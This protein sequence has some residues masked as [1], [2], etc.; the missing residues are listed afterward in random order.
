MALAKL[1]ELH[2]K[3]VPEFVFAH[4]FADEEV[5]AS[6]QSEQTTQRLSWVFAFLA[7]FISS[8]GLLGLVMFT[9]E[10][11]TKEVSIRKVLGASGSQVAALLS[12]D[13]FGLIL[14]A[15]VLSVPVSNFLLTNW[16]EGYQYRITIE[17]WT[18]A[19]AAGGAIITAL[20]TISFQTI[21]AART[22]PVD[23]LKMDG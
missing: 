21:K 2:Q 13:Y 3:L 5:A 22:N 1:E 11:R 17:W 12:R 4:Q 8:L 9:A 6:Y 18:Y 16:L 19:I 14:I 23:G 15:I 7:I 10:Q 20:A